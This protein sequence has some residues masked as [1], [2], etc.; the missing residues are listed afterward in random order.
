MVLLFFFNFSHFFLQVNKK[1]TLEKI[2]PLCNSIS[3]ATEKLEYQEFSY[4]ALRE[5]I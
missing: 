4:Q 5:E 2:L 3:A 1:Q